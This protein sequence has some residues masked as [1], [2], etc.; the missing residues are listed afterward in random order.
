MSR[1]QL[2]KGG[3]QNEKEFRWLYFL[4]FDKYIV[5]Y[6][7]KHYSDFQKNFSFLPLNL[8]VCDVCVT[9]FVIQSEHNKQHPEIA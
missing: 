4:I 5:T 3:L 9:V 8:G 2:T 1:G 6:P 7:A